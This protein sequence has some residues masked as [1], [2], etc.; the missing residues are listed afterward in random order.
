MGQLGGRFLSPRLWARVNGQGMAPDGYANGF[1][2]VDDF[3]CFGGTVTSNVGTYASE[4]GM[5]KSYE[6]TGD[7]ISQIKLT[8]GAITLTTD[9]TDNDEVWLQSGYGTGT[10]GTIS[11]TAGAD[12]LTI[13]EARF[14]VSKVT[15]TYNVF[16]GLSEEGL[17]AADTVSDAGAIASK[18]LIGFAVDEADGDALDFIYRKAGQA[19][20]TKITGVQ[21]LAA[22]TFYKCGFVYDP[23]APASERIQ[24]YIDN[25][26]ESTCVTATD[27]ATATFPDAEQLAFLAGVKNGSGAISAVTLDWWAFYQAG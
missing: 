9:T 16:V 1:A 6:D 27:I 24:V 20:Q 4:A 12:K 21:V 2:V 17:A 13:F 25:D 15:D 7:A 3:T 10:L 23:F 14:K 11:D 26:V 8:G 22:D 18:D 5:Y 19:L